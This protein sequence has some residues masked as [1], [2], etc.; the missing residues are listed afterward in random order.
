MNKYDIL[1]IGAGSV[2]VPLSYYL[3]GKGA[4]VA[5]IEKNCSVGRGQNRAAIGGIRATHSNPAKIKISQKT[6]DIVSRMDVEYG[7]DV[8]WYRGG[9]LF[10]V[11]TEEHE[12]ELR[13]LLEL[14]KHY[15][16]NIDWIPASRVEKLV[17]GINPEGLRGRTYSPKDGSASPLKVIDSF[18][19][20]AIDSAV[21]FYFN[22]EVTD[23]KINN[24]KIEQVVTD[25]DRY[26]ARLI[27]NAS[28]GDARDIGILADTDIPVFPDSHEGGITEPVQRFFDP[29]VI[30]L[31]EGSIS[32]NY[33]FYQN[34]EGQVV[35]CMTP[36]PKIP[37][38]DIYCTSEFLPE[39][40]RRMVD[41]YPRLRNI[42]V[43]RT[44]RGLY[45]MTPDGFPIIGYDPKIK[46]MF[47]TVGMCGHGFMLG[48]GL[49]KILAEVLIDKSPAHDD[50]LKELSPTRE[51][52]G[53]EKLE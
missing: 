5:V 50:I 28:G 35:F 11:Y 19:K 18:Y 37:G 27:I 14:Q 1:I 36:K 49:G 20:L 44:W 22:E 51:F 52:T 32:A 13:D 41:L 26:S 9:Y 2:G 47:L 7:F 21:D 42:R 25:K 38:K 45:P 16:L 48:P 30:D 6:I 53:N 29:M 24:N 34:I 31:R 8:D 40:I 23:F 43:R 39:V 46:N 33:Y 15:K 10:A 12:N 3:A 4:K 17:P